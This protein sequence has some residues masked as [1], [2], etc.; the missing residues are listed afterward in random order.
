VARSANRIRRCVPAEVPEICA[1]VND[2]A[3]A[4]KGVIPADCWHEP[5]MPLDELKRQIA[6]GVVF[7][8]CGEGAAIDGVMGIQD[9]GEVSLIRHAYVRTALRR[10]G[11][12]ETLLRYLEGTTDK[13]VLIGT[14]RAASWAIGFYEKNGYRLLEREETE[15]L[16]RR[17]W[18]ISQRQVE[19]SVVLANAQWR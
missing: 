1:I 7:W 18:S 15:R 9:R 3:Q 12:G 10:T 6:E 5:Y 4:Y 13:P 11:I 16:L 8:C 2:A 14:W 19:T 17:Y